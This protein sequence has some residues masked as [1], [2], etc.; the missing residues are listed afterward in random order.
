MSDEQATPEITDLGEIPA[1]ATTPETT[2]MLSIRYM[3]GV[4]VLVVTG[5]TAPE[6]ITAVDGSGTPSALYTAGPIVGP[7]VRVSSFSNWV[8]NT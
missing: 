2:G 8:N 1:T 6:T 4:P 3:D 7:G 5:G